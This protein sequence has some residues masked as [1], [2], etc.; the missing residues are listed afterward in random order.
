MC[1]RVCLTACACNK[2]CT[3][4]QRCDS[5]TVRRHRRSGVVGASGC[6]QEG[7]HLGER[8]QLLSFV[9]LSFAFCAVFERAVIA[10]VVPAAPLS[11]P[12][13]WSA[14][15]SLSLITSSC[16]L[17]HRFSPGSLTHPCVSDEFF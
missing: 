12:P 5:V 4:P 11:L 15:L 10:Y 9:A 14:P 7:S 8:E 2:S 13:T 6:L 3:F 1:V 17:T 16:C